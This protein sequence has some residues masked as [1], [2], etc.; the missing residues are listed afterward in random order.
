MQNIRRSLEYKQWKTAVKHRDGS[1][2]R[3]CGFKGN[4]HV[5]HIKPFDQYPQFALVIEN[6]LT[7]CGNCHSILSGK[8]ETTDLRLFLEGDAKIDQ[9]L[10][11]IE[12][13]FSKYLER[14]LRSGI[15]HT[16]EE[17]IRALFSHLDVYPNSMGK[18]MVELL[19]RIVDSYDWEDES[20]TKQRAIEWLRKARSEII[21]CRICHAKVRIHFMNEKSIIIACSHCRR[22][23][24]HDRT[25]GGP[26]PR[27][28]ETPVAVN[29]ISRYE[30]RVERSRNKELARQRLEA[31]EKEAERREAKRRREQEI[32][33]KD[34]SLGEYET[35]LKNKNDQRTEEKP[36]SIANLIIAS[37]ICIVGLCFLVALAGGC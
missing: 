1:A 23:F 6:G 11:A 15:E 8:E 26:S 28:V 16:R 14:K 7:L 4:L 17:G 10:R 34:R 9:Q 25:E 29:A 30:Q 2:C 27:L 24:R 32:I 18:K 21:D 22:K 37:W 33:A 20:P 36:N 3:R 13:K 19:I 12:G 5:H 31:Q 35:H